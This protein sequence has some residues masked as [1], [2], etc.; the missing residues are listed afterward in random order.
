MQVAGALHNWKTGR[1][2]NSDF[3]QELL[4]TTYKSLL[5]LITGLREDKPELFHKTMREL[6]IKTTYVAPT[7]PPDFLL[8]VFHARQSPSTSNVTSLGSARNVIRL[9]LADDDDDE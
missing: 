2:Q 6:Y 9:D 1:F 8:I 5:K 4:E 7:P 3:S